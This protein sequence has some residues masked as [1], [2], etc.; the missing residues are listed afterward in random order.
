MMK[1][2][3]LFVV[4]DSFFGEIQKTWELEGVW[5]SSISFE[6]GEPER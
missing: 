6:F 5:K 4:Y 3:K 1:T 2:F